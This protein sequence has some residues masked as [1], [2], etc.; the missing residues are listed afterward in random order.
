MIRL[1]EDLHIQFVCRIMV[2]L[3]QFFALYVIA[4][5][6]YSPGG[7]FQG[8]CILGASFILMMIAYDIEYVK[9]RFP[10]KFNTFMVAF[11]VFL[12]AAIGALC[13]ILGAEYLNYGILHKILPADPVKVRAL[14]TLGIEIGVGITVSAVMLSI[15]LNLSTFGKHEKSEV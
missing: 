13:L 4:H 12:Y 6:H 5:G 14:G 7:G 2:P 9:K 3:I 1:I 10:E 15:F 11:G 8:G